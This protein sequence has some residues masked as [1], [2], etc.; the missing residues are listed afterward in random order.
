[1]SYDKDHVE[2]DAY[3]LVSIHCMCCNEPVIVR[4]YM[5]MPHKTKPEEI[6]RVMTLRRL[7]N[8]CEIE[9]VLA[10]GSK[11]FLPHCTTC[12]DTQDRD[13]AKATTLIH[14]GWEKEMI[15]AGR[16]PQTVS[17]VMD[18]A[19]KNKVLSKITEKE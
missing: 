6:V 16:S 7:P 17:R 3:G 8:H 4:S 9:A 15:H 1:M 5:E 12:R 2:F 19:R 18:D 10:D 13:L 11:T 14:K